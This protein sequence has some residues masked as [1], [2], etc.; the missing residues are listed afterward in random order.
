MAIND[1]AIVGTRQVKA[2]TN[3][4]TTTNGF[5]RFVNDEIFTTPPPS[6]LTQMQ[7]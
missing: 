1:Y 2:N 7:S 4:S 5:I 3:E 6:Q